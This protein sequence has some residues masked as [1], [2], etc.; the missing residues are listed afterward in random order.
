MANKPILQFS[1][2]LTLKLPNIFN[3]YHL[4]Q[5]WAFKYDSQQKGIGIHADDAKVNVNLWLTSE[6]ANLDNHSGGMIIW[7]KKPN[8]TSNFSDYNSS[9]NSEKML[10]DVS[11]SDYIRIPYK[12]NRAVIFNS[13]LY[14]ATDDINFDN[15]YINRRINVTFLYS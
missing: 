15:K 11:E 9:V 12:A 10:Q 6:N 1:K 13:K 7:K 4:T 14:H 5:A 8:E 3:K 2:D